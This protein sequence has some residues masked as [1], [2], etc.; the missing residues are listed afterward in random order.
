MHVCALRESTH[1][2]R[3][4]RV[5]VV[6]ARQRREPVLPG[7]VPQLQLQVVPD[8]L[9]VSCKSRG[10]SHVCHATPPSGMPH[11]I[12]WH[13]GCSAR[14]VRAAAVAPVHRHNLTSEIG[15]E[16]LFVRFVERSVHIPVR[17]KART[18]GCVCE[19]A[20]GGSH[21]RVRICA[22]EKVR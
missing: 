10:C 22:S 11:G 20:R 14:R 17:M 18:C 6:R 3:G 7:E 2:D 4:V 16:R 15:A 21:G 12:P 1:D 5:P 19:G 13:M 9:H 8:G